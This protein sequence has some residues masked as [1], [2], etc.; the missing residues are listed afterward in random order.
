M[1][2]GLIPTKESGEEEA[3]FLTSSTP[4]IRAFGTKGLQTV[5]GWG[6]S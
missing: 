6:F 1:A 4:R 5:S 3:V 2:L